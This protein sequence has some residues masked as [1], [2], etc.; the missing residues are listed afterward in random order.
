MPGVFKAK[1]A[2]VME[3]VMPIR[4]ELLSSLLSLRLRDGTGCDEDDIA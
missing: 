4:M 1:K 2:C 3:R